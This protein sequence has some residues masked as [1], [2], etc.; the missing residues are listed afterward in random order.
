MVGVAGLRASANLLWPHPVTLHRGIMCSAVKERQLERERFLSS[1][2]SNINPS[3]WGWKWHISQTHHS[4]HKEYE[5][6][7]TAWFKARSLIKT[8]LECSRWEAG[9]RL[10][11]CYYITESCLLVCPQ[12]L[13]RKWGSL[14]QQHC[15]TKTGQQTDHVYSY[16]L[17]TDL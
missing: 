4:R 10:C 3:V 15:S 5:W 8:K 16:I 17:I 7:G 9:K 2:H 14:Q 12:P 1:S 13:Q 6:G 11:P